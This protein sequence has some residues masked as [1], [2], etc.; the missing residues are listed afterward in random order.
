MKKLTM[1]VF[2]LLALASTSFGVTTVLTTDHASFLGYITPGV[3]SDPVSETTYVQTLVDLFPGTNATVY[4]AA[5]QL[6]SAFR[7]INPLPVVLPDAVFA[8]KYNVDL[9]W[10]ATTTFS[11]SPYYYVLAKYGNYNGVK[12]S[13]VW[14]VGDL[15][16]DVNIGITEGLS[17]V[18]LFGTRPTNHVDEGA[19]TL[20]LIGGA[21]AGLV[22]IRRKM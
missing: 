8:D 13:H 7:W 20:I 6:N 17:H 18:S 10:P 21:L 2:A 14:Y 9:T 19:N 5:G 15:S 4:S 12:L 16:G 22:A 1:L 11:I 3:A